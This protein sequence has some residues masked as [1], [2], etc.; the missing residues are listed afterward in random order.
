MEKE[1]ICIGCPMGCLMSVIFE[2][3]GQIVITGNSCPK[4]KEYAANE[5]F[6]PTRMVTSTVRIE[7][8]I[9]PLLSVR[10][11]QPV[12]KDSVR[13]CMAVLR[14]V[15]VDAPVYAGQVIIRNIVDT[16]ADIVATKTME[17]VI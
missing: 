7:N 2:E 12:P 9:Y 13:K 1:I 10:T 17:R 11:S 8:A 4:G 14:E 6:N 15:K 16:Q 5:C 3:N